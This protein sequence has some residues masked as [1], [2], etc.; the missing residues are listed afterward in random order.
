MARIGF[1]D[2]FSW[3]EAARQLNSSDWTGLQSL[4]P[5]TV[6]EIEGRRTA[7]DYAAQS[8]TMFKEPEVKTVEP[9]P[10]KV[11]PKP[12]KASN[13]DAFKKYA[14]LA[15]LVGIDPP[16]LL[17]EEFKTFLN[18]N[19]LP[20]FNLAEVVKYMDAKARK[21]SE[22]QAGWAWH[23]LRIKDNASMTFGTRAAWAT[24]RNGWSTGKLISVGSDYY[25]YDGSGTTKAYKRLI[26]FHALE[27]V[28][29]IEKAFGSR[30]KMFVSEYAPL[31]EIPYPDP[32]LMAVIPNP[33]VIKG[34]GRFV[35]DVWDEPGFGLE[36]MLK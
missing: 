8:A 26:P 10:V 19:D 22:K 32:F 23:P 35:I 33:N 30:V 6:G 28:A 5:E 15:A 12:V 1:N 36:Q 16:D 2:G 31:P 7:Q 34:E 29:L 3:V 4:P 14:E 20:V 18:D 17:I 24:D 13:K 27:K 11:I 9:D 25:A 21:E